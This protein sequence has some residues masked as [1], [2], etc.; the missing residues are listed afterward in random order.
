MQVF[1]ITENQLKDSLDQCQVALS[2]K[3]LN[4]SFITDVLYISWHFNLDTNVKKWSN[5][6]IIISQVRSILVKKQELF[7]LKI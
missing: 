5:L 7:T 6:S 3:V 2:S 1:T 4:L